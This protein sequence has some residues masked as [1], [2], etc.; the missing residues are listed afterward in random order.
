[1]Y[2]D[3]TS[4]VWEKNNNN[5]HMFIG[6]VMNNKHVFRP[7]PLFSN[8]FWQHSI[9]TTTLVLIVILKQRQSRK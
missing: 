2:Y 9:S 8:N 6:F 3:D 1:M 4:I 5:K 7:L